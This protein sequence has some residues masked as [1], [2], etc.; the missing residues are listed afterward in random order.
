[1]GN[2]NVKVGSVPVAGVTGAYGLG[3]RNER[4]DTLI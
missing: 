1:M 3:M 4:G 2:I